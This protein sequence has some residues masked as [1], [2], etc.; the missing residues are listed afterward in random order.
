MNICYGCGYLV[1][2]FLR[3]FGLFWE[4]ILLWVILFSFNL[5]G[6]IVDKWIFDLNVINWI[7]FFKILFFK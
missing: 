4:M 1:F 7:F 6:F 3:V 2:I 5:D